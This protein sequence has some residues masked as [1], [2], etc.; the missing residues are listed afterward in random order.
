MDDTDNSCLKAYLVVC[1]GRFAL[2]HAVDKAHAA[3]L[4]YE[5]S[6][7]VHLTGPGIPVGTPF[8]SGN[9]RSTGVGN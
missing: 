4:A 3:V 8:I 7:T 6:G 5:F 9:R 1:A 2:G